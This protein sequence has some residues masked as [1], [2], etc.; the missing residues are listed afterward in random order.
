V[1]NTREH[2]ACM[3]YCE[4]LKICLLHLSW[5]MSFAI[6]I[7]LFYLC[8]VKYKTIQNCDDLQKLQEILGRTNEPCFHLMCLSFYSYTQYKSTTLYTH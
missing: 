8:L 7:G 6:L 3:A 4:F 5:N 2:V 1:Q